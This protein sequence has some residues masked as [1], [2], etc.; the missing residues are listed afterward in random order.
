VP[1]WLTY[2]QAADVLGCHVSN[3]AKLIR[4][5]ELTS[6]GDSDRRKPALRRRDVEALADAPA[7][8]PVGARA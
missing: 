2:Q 4:K 3:V 7:V 5:G 6:R 1:D 8:A